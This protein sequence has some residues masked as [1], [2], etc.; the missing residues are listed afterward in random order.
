MV[1]QDGTVSGC[2]PEMLKQ[3]A[4]TDHVAAGAVVLGTMNEPTGWRGG[5]GKLEL[6]LREPTGQ[7]RKQAVNSGSFSSGAVCWAQEPPGPA[8][9]L[10]YYRLAPTGTTRQ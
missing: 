6:L 4:V 10:Q 2:A 9:Q 1:G 5:T 7:V 8:Q 3:A